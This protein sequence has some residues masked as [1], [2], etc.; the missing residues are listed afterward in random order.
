MLR[1]TRGFC[2]ST[3]VSGPKAGAV[4]RR[5]KLKDT[6]QG[7]GQKGLGSLITAGQ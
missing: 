3:V 4:G 6:A 5:E 1:L 7:K 2:L